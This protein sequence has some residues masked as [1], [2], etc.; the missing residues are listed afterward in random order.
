MLQ[1]ETD[2][3]LARRLQEEEEEAGHRPTRRAAANASKRSKTVESKPFNRKAAGDGS[4]KSA[5]PKRAGA[6]ITAVMVLSPALAAFLG[7]AEV[8][9]GIFRKRGAWAGVV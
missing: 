2:E 8:R 1:L 7:Q 9:A 6:G 3:D 4:P 5:G